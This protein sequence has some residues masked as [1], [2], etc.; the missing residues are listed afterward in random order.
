LHDLAGAAG[1]TLEEMNVALFPKIEGMNRKRK[2][3]R[4]RGIEEEKEGKREKGEEKRE[5][6][7]INLHPIASAQHFA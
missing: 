6:R 1:D 3:G 5:K 7:E 4:K 2:R